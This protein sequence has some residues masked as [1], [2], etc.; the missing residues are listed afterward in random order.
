MDAE[1]RDLQLKA[2]V[3]LPLQDAMADTKPRK[4]ITAVSLAEHFAFLGW[5]SVA[6]TTVCHLFFGLL[7]SREER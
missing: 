3:Q 7:I 6:L 4:K 1:S 2:R 5:H